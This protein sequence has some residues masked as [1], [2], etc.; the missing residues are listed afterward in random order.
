[1]YHMYKYGYAYCRLR[2]ASPG[3]AA[4]TASTHPEYTH[5]NPIVAIVP[6]LAHPHTISGTP[7]NVVLVCMNGSGV[8][9]GLRSTHWSTYA[10]YSYMLFVFLPAP[11]FMQA[12]Y[13]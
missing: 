1:M 11:L 2:N 12:E 10:I 13:I 8:G 9:A 6:G 7:L 4:T 3:H 5:I